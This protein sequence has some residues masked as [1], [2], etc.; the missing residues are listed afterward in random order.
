MLSYANMS[1]AAVAI[2][3]ETFRKFTEMTSLLAQVGELARDIN[4][5]VAD[6]KKAAPLATFLLKAED[7]SADFWEMNY[8]LQ[9]SFA[10]MSPDEIDE[11][12][13]DAV[14]QVRK[15]KKA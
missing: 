10:D 1:K 11:L 9:E 7:M 15:Q 14:T 13:A 5:N 4:L 3:A 6:P 8:Q 12:V 2:P